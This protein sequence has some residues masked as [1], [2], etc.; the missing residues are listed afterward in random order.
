MTRRKTMNFFSKSK[1]TFIKTEKNVAPANSE[2]SKI[3]FDILE[4]IGGKANIVFI[5]YCVTRLRL[6]IKDYAAV[7][8]KKPKSAGVSGII[9]CAPKSVA[10]ILG[11]KAQSVAEELQKL[12]K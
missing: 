10:L 12:C 9:R 11:P 2:Y 1:K 6:E 8:E 4:G 5:D 7:D 3:A